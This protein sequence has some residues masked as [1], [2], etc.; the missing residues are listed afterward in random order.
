MSGIPQKLSDLPRFAGKTMEVKSPTFDSLPEGATIVVAGTYEKN[1]TD[2]TGVCYFCGS[3]VWMDQRDI[4][5]IAAMT[6]P[7]ISCPA[8]YF[9][10]EPQEPE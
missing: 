7:V 10:T 9:K 3:K 1:P 6:A 8:C 2:P 5:I 4:P